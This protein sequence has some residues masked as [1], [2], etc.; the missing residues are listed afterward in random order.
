MIAR[1]SVLIFGVSSIGYL[2]SFIALIFVARYM[3]PIPLGIIGFGSGF[4][5]LFHFL[6]YFGYDTAHIKRVS[7]GKDLD[8]CIGTY[9]TVK[10][11][12]AA[13]TIIVVIGATFIWKLVLHGEFESQT[14]EIVLY[15]LL[16]STVITNL[17]SIM[18][19][20]F[21][22]R[23]ETAKQQIP[24][25]TGHISQAVSRIFVA[26]MS[27]G[28]FMLA[29]AY[30]LGAIITF[31]IAL[32]LFRGY[33]ISR[34]NKDYFKNYSIYALPIVFGVMGGTILANFDRVMIQLFIGTQE[35]GYYFTAER[36]IIFMMFIGTGLSTILIPTISSH[37]TKGNFEKIRWTVLTAER[38]ISMISTPVLA[39]T[40]LFS[41]TIIFIFLGSTFTS[42][43][44][45]LSI[46]SA[47]MWV[48][49]TIIP[50]SSQICGLDKPGIVGK[51]YIIMAVLNILLNLLFIPKNLMGINLL[52][53]GIE[54][55]AI[56]T[57]ISYLV[58]MTIYR[59]AVYKLAKTKPNPRVL[60]HLLAAVGMNALLYFI[61]I[62][63]PIY[64]W[65]WF[66]VF[67]LIGIGIYLGLLILMR[68]FTKED[69]N[70]FY[71][72]LS[73]KKMVEY[74][75]SEI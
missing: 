72:T 28:V 68:E 59:A 1:K 42:A 5:G 71:K 16:I 24:K 60:L 67:A 17:S 6:T 52:G 51:T 29:G 43:Y 31:I 66:L 18:L 55:A 58:Q 32:Y 61:A 70:F 46:F 65:Y 49:I 21:A 63:F 56:A 33:P 47:I 75:R 26:I 53:L 50:A 62:R 9:L 27:L 23:K 13:V 74:I 48:K 39:F 64:E 25:L 44:L 37:S 57:L 20:T 10:I 45:V 30:V 34:P 4:V 35:V 73:P 38:Y 41:Q 11:I 14:H 3:G 2:L 40:F 54:G 36:L 22:A 7:E 15:I 8:K 12:L 69:F 19:S